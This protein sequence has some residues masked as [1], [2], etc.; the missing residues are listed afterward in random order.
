MHGPAEG[1]RC[2]Q[3]VLIKEITALGQASRV[4]K[5]R[6]KSDLQAVAADVKVSPHDRPGAGK[7]RRVMIV[8]Q[9]QTAVD[10]SRPPQQGPE[11]RQ[12]KDQ[13]GAQ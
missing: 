10:V 9:S 5:G 4:D 12:G 6:V 7:V 11:Q 8:H 3:L 1:H 13:R 2:Q